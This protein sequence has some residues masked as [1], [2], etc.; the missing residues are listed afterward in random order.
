MAKYQICCVSYDFKLM[1]VRY[2]YGVGTTAALRCE[3]IPPK[4]SRPE[5]T[6]ESSREPSGEEEID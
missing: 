2:S 1:C 6:K 5:E 4:R 3:D